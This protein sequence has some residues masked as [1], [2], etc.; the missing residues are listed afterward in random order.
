M[1][2]DWVR[3]YQSGFS[4]FYRLIDSALIF[5]LWLLC[6]WLFM[7]EINQGCFIAGLLATG[8]F[9]YI[10]ESMQLYRSW[11]SGSFSQMMLLT[12]ST[13]FLVCVLLLGIAFVVK[14]TE[15]FSRLAVGYWFTFTLLVLCGW[16]YVLRVVLRYCRTHD[17]N[18]RTAAIL[19]VTES[20]LRLAADQAKNPHYGI[21][22][23][24][25]Y[26]DRVE[27]REEFSNDYL[28]A[29]GELPQFGSSAD[30]V[31]RAK[32]GEIDIVYIAMPMKAQ[33]RISSVLKALSDTTATV[34]LVPDFF[35]YNLLHSRWHQVGDTMLLSVHD[36][37]I[38]GFGGWMKRMEDLLI[39]SLILLLISPLLL[40]I[41]A[42]IKL[43][44]RGPVLFKQ[45]RYGL[46]GEAI[47]VW[48]FRSM[49]VQE[50]GGKVTQA[51]RH[52][53]RI[54][55]FGRFL[56]RTSLDELP[57][58]I[59]VLQ[60]HMSIVGPR[61]HAVAHNEAYRSV[62]D[63]YM[64]RHK[65]KPGITGWAQINGWRGETDTVDKMV[66]R[67]EFDLQYIRNWSLWLDMKII[68][69]TVVKGFVN[70][71]AY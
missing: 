69:Q 19:G 23:I 41:A 27:R 46:A 17:F 1:K 7:H 12:A 8:F 47:N 66:K 68:A 53:T 26:D 67:I 35:V 50:N 9:T 71:N 48:K 54:T 34:H 59:N 65:V 18:T 29:S 62:I 56:R 3:F 51:T 58:F 28:L 37:P 32:R 55:P 36:T 10:A 2:Q 13:W 6:C 31:D 30:L 22:V 63:G 57:Q 43:T 14:V 20:G 45:T 15:D 11:R 39:S 5:G 38:E 4:V 60:G 40:L 70:K 52:D 42:A 44:S 33:E 24:G 16:R 64:L 49:T 25:F 61:P 21:R